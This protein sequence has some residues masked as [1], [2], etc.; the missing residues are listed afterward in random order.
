MPNI[1]PFNPW[2]R[3]RLCS[4]TKFIK[5]TIAPEKIPEEPEPAIARPTMKAVKL[6]GSAAN[7]RA[8]FEEGN[9]GN[10]N[11]FG[12]IESID[13]AGKVLEGGACKHVGGA[14]P[15]NVAKG[16]QV[17]CYGGDGCCNYCAVL[18]VC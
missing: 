16:M 2:S 11:I 17:V 13:S 18:N 4:G 3:G 6:E 8:N 1:A 7:D 5:M 15:S 14:V 10:K 9:G 12:I